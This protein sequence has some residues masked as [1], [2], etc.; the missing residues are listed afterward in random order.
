MTAVIF[1]L[2]GTLSDSTDRCYLAQEGKWEEFH[3]AC[4]NDPV[5]K[6][7]ANLADAMFKAGYKIYMVT[8]RPNSVRNLT[9]KWLMHHTIM[10]DKLYMRKTGDLRED[11]VIKSEILDS[12]KDDILFA[13][14]DKTSVVN[15]Y[16]EHGITCLQCKDTPY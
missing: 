11:Y 7:I 6:P 4:G 15:M 3:N 2:D 16:R 9:E 1:D 10:Y 13:V 14:E 8:G 5:V 12:I